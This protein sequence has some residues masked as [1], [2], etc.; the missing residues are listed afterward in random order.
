M[1]VHLCSMFGPPLD[2]IFHSRELPIIIGRG[3]QADVSID[4]RWISRVHCQLSAEGG[5]LFVRDL[6]SKHG[7]YVNRRLVQRVRLIPGDVLEMGLTTILVE[8]EDANTH[9]E[10]GGI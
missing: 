7:T 9:V 4:D 3:E 2:L 6:E 8:T 5:R 10:N 1:K